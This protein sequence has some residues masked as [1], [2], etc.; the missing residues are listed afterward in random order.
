MEVCLAFAADHGDLPWALN[1][2]DQTIYTRKESKSRQD[3]PGPI[4]SS[5]PSFTG[6]DR[7][8]AASDSGSLSFSLPPQPEFDPVSRPLWLRIVKIPNSAHAKTRQ[9][10][11]TFIYA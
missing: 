1:S 8:A 3:C 5:V 6:K 9:S 10:R 4:K 2:R 7:H 11:S